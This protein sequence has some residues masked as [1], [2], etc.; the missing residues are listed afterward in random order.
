MRSSEAER[1]AAVRVV[2]G[3]I[4]VASSRGSP[5]PQQKTEEWSIGEGGNLGFLVKGRVV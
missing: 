3:S 2:T 4:P 1:V 5:R